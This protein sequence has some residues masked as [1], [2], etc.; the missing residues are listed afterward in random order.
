MNKYYDD[1]IEK[2]MIQL[3]DSLSEKDRRRYAAVE[4]KKLGH[5]GIVYISTLFNCDYKTIRR[6]LDDLDDKEKMNIAEVRASGGG[7]KSKI[8]SIDGIDEIFLEILKLNTAGDPMNENVKWT[9]LSRAQIIKEM[10]KKGITVSKNIVK[11][12]FKKHGFVKRKMQKKLATGTHKDRNEQFL[13][14]D[15]L[16]EKYE[17]EGNPVISI[18]SKKKSI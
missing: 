5:G 3:Y 17:K 15:E 8:D 13:K 2:P 18:D 9:H 6:G 11:K 7:P 10:K 14:I 1:E 12:L 16:R 4:A